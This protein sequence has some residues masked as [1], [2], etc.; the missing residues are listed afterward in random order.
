MYLK[1]LTI[2]A[3]MLTLAAPVHAQSATQ[4]NDLVEALSLN[5]IV[6][7]MREEGLAGS[8]TLAENMLGGVPV[9]TFCSAVPA[10]IR[11]TTR[12]PLARS[13]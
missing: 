13:L 10:S 7:I 2:T 1:P 5:R 8:D 11:W 9:P 12:M 6:E 3:C 4:I